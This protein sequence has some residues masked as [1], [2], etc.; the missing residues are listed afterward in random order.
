MGDSRRV[1]VLKL[2]AQLWVW[3]DIKSNSEPPWGFDERGDIAG[4]KNE[5][6]SCMKD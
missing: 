6:G 5:F 4:E 2:R 1:R 3:M